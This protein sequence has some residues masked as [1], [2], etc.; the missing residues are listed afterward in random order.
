MT[1]RIKRMKERLD[2]KCFP[3]CAEKYG[4]ILESYKQNEG[5]PIIMQRA[6]A[7]AN[8][9]DKK[10]IYIDPD[11]LIVGNF[12]ARPMGMEAA[13]NGPTWPDDDL[14]ALVASGGVSI[15]DEDR[16]ILR[17]YDDYWEGKGRTKDE[18]QG[19]FYDDDRLW[20]FISRGFLC[21]AWKDREKGRGQGAAGQG[22]WAT[23]VGVGTLFTPDFEKFITTGVAQTIRECEEEL[24]NLRYYNGDAVEKGIYLRSALTVLPAI[25]RICNRYADLAEKMAAEEA[26]PQ[27]AKELRQI[28]ETCRNVPER[29]ATSF[30]E[31]V[32]SFF[33]YWSLCAVGT[34][35][36]GRF[37]QY[38]YPF[39]KKDLEEGKITYDEAFE[40]LECLR[41]KIMQYNQVSGGPQQREKWA[42]MARWHNFI[43][44]GTDNDGND[45]T[46]DITYMLLD[47]AMDTM[48]PH[49]TLTLRVHEGT[50]AE[51]L[52]KA[53]ACIRTG[54]GMPA[55]ISEKSYRNFVMSTGVP[56]EEANKFA[57]AGCLDVQVPGNSKNNAF[58]MFEVPCVLELAIFDGQNPAT[59]IQHGEH[60]GNLYD[61]KTYEEF[62]E[63]FKK[64]LNDCMALVSEEHNILQWVSKEHFPD[65]IHSI[66]AADGVKAG[67]DLLKRDLLFENSSGINMVGIV[68]TINSL[69]AVKKLVFDDKTVDAKTLYDALKANWVGY[70][71]IQKLCLEAPKF[72]NDNDEVDLIGAKLF[73]DYST[74]ARTFTQT[75]GKP[76]IASGISITAHAP[77]GSYT[78]ATPDGRFA[79]ETFADGSTSPVQGTD[80]NGPT[81]VFKSAMKLNQDNFMATLMNMKFH[82]SALKTDEDLDKLG[83]L[84][85][86]YLTNGGKH[87][88]FNVAD[89][90]VLMEAKKD[91]E[92]YKDLVV[93]VAGYSSYFVVLTP[94][95]QDEIIKR[96]AHEL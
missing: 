71:D 14:D 81:A 48:T 88:Q 46:N 8:Y 10:T 63:A 54:I 78:G 25:I 56:Y 5:R 96:T 52:R 67:K 45:I 89:E 7:V 47:G 85:K 20:N 31:A 51:L 77:G 94:R 53:C 1:E 68:N 80:L 95:I 90:K 36:G 65:I 2:V 41:M 55:M 13:V 34:T 29:P 35:P 75:S 93:R 70:E 74:L 83:A 87:V 82:K 6:I 3:I 50:P 62:Y 49:F 26:D 86:T 30:R 92:K 21:P 60:T 9:L 19:W 16:K 11:E 61:F 43:I 32:Q 12:A 69:A 42:G 15:T 17:S 27:R 76:C 64:Q 33:F 22:G 58:G 44:G 79:G 24:K 39:Y 4:I 73:D 40:L 84:I 66:Y 23:C 72:G 38:M 28:A 57:I 18:K 37:D 91:K 59:G